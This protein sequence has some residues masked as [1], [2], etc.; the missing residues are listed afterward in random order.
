MLTAN[1][2]ISVSAFWAICASTNLYAMPIDMF[3]PGRAAFGVAVLTFAY[4]LMQA[5]FSLG[6]G[7]VVDHVGFNNVCFGMAGL[8]FIGVAILRLSTRKASVG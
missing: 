1:I 3:G 2:A 6:I 4:G 8:P 7:K 5:F